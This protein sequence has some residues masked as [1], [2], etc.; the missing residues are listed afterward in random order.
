MI[1]RELLSLKRNHN[2]ELIRITLNLG[3]TRLNL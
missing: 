2:Q 1:I 3:V